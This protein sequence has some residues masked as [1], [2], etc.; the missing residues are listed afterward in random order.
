M[1]NNI[2]CSF[3]ENMLLF[4]CQ[5][6]LNHSATPTYVKVEL[7]VTYVSLVLSITRQ[8]TA[9]AWVSM[10]DRIT[11]F[12]EFVICYVLEKVSFVL[13]SAYVKLCAFNSKQLPDPAYFTDCFHRV[14]LILE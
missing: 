8:V 13:W 9:H 1:T 7:I 3:L 2:F 5:M 6:I 12:V 4:V 11:S 10:S 14:P